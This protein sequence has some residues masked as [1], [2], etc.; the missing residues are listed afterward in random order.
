MRANEFINEH[1]LV[2]R[3]NKKT[4]EIKLAWR[5]E[6]GTRIGRTVPQVGDCS[7]APDMAKSQR[8]KTTRKRTGKAQARKTKK[9]KRINPHS[10][11]IQRLNKALSAYRKK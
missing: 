8:M 9:A 3:R 5:C 4:G 10:R 11:L 1:R 6:S 2:W 7:A